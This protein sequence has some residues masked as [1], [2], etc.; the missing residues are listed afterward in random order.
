MC[1]GGLRSTNE[2]PLS[3]TQMGSFSL[4]LS[5]SALFLCGERKRGR[6]RETSGNEV[7]SPELLFPWLP[8]CLPSRGR[9]GQWPQGKAAS[10]WPSSLTLAPST[11]LLILAWLDRR[12]RRRELF[13]L[14]TH[15]FPLLSPSPSPLRSWCF[16]VRRRSDMERKG[17][18]ERKTEEGGE[19]GREGKI[20]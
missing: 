8:A 13:S 7:L 5:P 3:G 9:G 2:W 20:D 6:E 11:L 17:R 1:A 12:G 18:E 10:S 4:S 16:P 15:L 19:G 14:T